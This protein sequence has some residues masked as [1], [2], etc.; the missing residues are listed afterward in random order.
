MSLPFPTSRLGIRSLMS[1]SLTL[2]LCLS[3]LMSTAMAG[4]WDGKEVTRDGILRVENTDKPM[5]K[6]ETIN[7][8][9][10]W[11]LGGETDDEDE[12]FGAITDMAVGE[13]GDIYLLDKVLNQ[14]KIFTADGEYLRTIGREGEGPGEF[15]SSNGMALIA[16]GTVCVMSQR[17][18]RIVLLTPDGLPAGTQPLPQVEGIDFVGVTKTHNHGGEIFINFQY[19]HFEEGGFTQMRRIARIDGEGNVRATFA[20]GERGLD[21]SNPVFREKVWDDFQNRWDVNPDGT[22]VV[23]PTWG[24][25]E[26]EVWSPEGELRHVITRELP[27]RRRKAAELD[28]LRM[29]YE[30]ALRNVP[31][32]SAEVEPFDHPVITVYSR[33]DDTVWVLNCHG[34]FDRPEGSIGRFDV[35]DAQGRFLREVTLLGEGEPM[36]D[37]Y[38]FVGDRLYVMRGQL[39]AEVLADGG[40]DEAVAGREAEPMSVICY[41]LNR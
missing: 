2:L 36:A 14:V 20:K 6:A 16:D 10:L 38:Y 24:E 27:R 11:R 26:V 33:D 39:D 7:M 37:G 15:R 41:D 9:E 19:N 3:P 21:F 18:E 32:S 34:G 13:N 5:H 1:L 22:V 29:Q 17:P 31:G 35:F 28:L 12:F 40:L 4:K 8:S 25:Y 23:A 30:P